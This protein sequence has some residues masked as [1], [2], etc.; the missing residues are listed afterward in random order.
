MSVG[1]EQQQH[2]NQSVPPERLAP[3]RASLSDRVLDAMRQPLVVVNGQLRVIS[4]NRAFYDFFA[5]VPERCIGRQLT[6]LG[7]CFDFAALQALVARAIAG[8]GASVRCESQIEL[9]RLRRCVAFLSAQL[10]C[11]EKAEGTEILVTFHDET[12]RRRDEAALSSP[13]EGTVCNAPG[14]APVL[15]GADHDLHQTPHASCWET[16]SNGNVPSPTIFIVDDDSAVRETM[17]ARFEDEEWPVEVYASGEAFLDSYRS[18][19]AGC[20]VAD[21]WLPHMSGFELL[22]RLHVRGHALPTIMITGHADIRLAVR[23]IKMGAIGFLEK[24]VLFDELLLN[25]ERALKLTRTWAVRSAW[26]ETAQTRIA[27]LTVRERQIMQLVLDGNPNKQ[28]AYVLGLSQRTV[29]SHRATIMRKL[30]VRSLS[31]L[32]HLAIAASPDGM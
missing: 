5:T 22:E 16:G 17:Q 29:E 15:T 25:I 9:P 4:A 26:R 19:H 6:T 28:M 3:I 13:Q 1:S 11:G 12:E 23:A 30:E 21:A 24:P 27:S 20:L 32:I 8:A 10:L 18:S 2:Q 14:K 31:E 7:C